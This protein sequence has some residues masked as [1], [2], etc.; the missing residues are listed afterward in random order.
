MRPHYPDAEVYARRI[1]EAVAAW[2]ALERDLGRALYVERGALA[3]SLAEGD[4]TD[5]CRA[6]F[7]RA[8][9]PYELLRGN[10]LGARFPMIRADDARFG[11]HTASGG[12][13]LCDRALTGL[14]A[15][16]AARG[17]TLVEGFRA[18]A[19]DWEGGRVTAADGRTL[20]GDVVVLAAG[21]GLPGLAG[22]ATGVAFA[23][24]RCVV[25]YADPPP[26]WAA[27]W[28]TAP[29]W[30]NLG[31]DADEVWGAPPA[32]GLPMKLGLGR[33]TRPGDP[34]AERLLTAADVEATL[35]VYRARLTD[36]AAIRAR[37]AHANFYTAAPEER[38]VLKRIG[39]GVVLSA[40]SGHG[41]KFGALTGLDA[42]EAI[43]GGDFDA[44]ARKLGGFDA[45]VEGA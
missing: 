20:E 21:I 1:P 40:D 13:L 12:L 10:E 3:L 30:V 32:L 28:E 22:E 4:W 11:L 42:A 8:G 27:A 31:A 43:D 38:F 23:P 25:V 6:T 19:V 44:I 37:T 24:M 18:T 34:E 17:A 35:A 36:G 15:W 45:A 29:V 9:V 2:R 5:R 14:A 41:F 16:L 39:R 7:D 26:R 33:I